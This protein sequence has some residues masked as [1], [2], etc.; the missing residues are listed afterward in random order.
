M[1][2]DP[3]LRA[4]F[5]AALPRVSYAFLEARSPAHVSWER[6][7]AAYLQ[8]SATYASE[9]DE[10]ARRAWRVRRAQLHHLA[11]ASSPA[12]VANLVNELLAELC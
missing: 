12:L 5:V 11:M 6:L 3:V 2:P 7:P 8:L 10:A 9:A 1:I 4:A